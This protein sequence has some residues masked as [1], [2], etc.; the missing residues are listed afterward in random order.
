[1]EKKF[2]LICSELLEKGVGEHITFGSLCAEADTDEMSMN[3]LFY[4]K[5]GMSGEEVFCKFLIDSIV[6]AV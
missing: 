3:N 2:A 6:I 1:M 4:E 5:F